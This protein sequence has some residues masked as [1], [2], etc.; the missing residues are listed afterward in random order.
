[1]E[2]R[3]RLKDKVAVA[4]GAAVGIGKEISHLNRE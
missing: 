2:I 1:M 3:M 4:T